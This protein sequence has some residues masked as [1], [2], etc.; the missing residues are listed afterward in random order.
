MVV[1]SF[2]DLKGRS[3]LLMSSIDVSRD[4]MDIKYGL[5]SESEKHKMTYIL[6]IEQWTPLGL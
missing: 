4:V 6:S 2:S 5:K 1:P 3:L